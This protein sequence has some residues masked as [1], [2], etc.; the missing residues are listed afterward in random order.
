MYSLIR[1]LVCLC[2]V[3][4]LLFA[5]L[6]GIRQFVSEHQPPGTNTTIE[7]RTVILERLRTLKELH[8][9]VATLQ[10]IVTDTQSSSLFGVGMGTNKV[11]YI[12]VGEV[13][14]GVNL[15]KLGEQDITVHGKSVRIALSDPEI[16]DAKIDVNQSG[17]YDV[18][19]STLFCPERYSMQDE[20]QR[21]ALVAIVEAAKSTALLETAREQAK[22]SITSLLKLMG[23]EVISIEFDSSN[24]TDGKSSEKQTNEA[25]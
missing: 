10:A 15:S 22:Q 14:A 19:C 17:L 12:A 23:F 4:V 7:V 2:F 11:I 3:C 8:T 18:R 20:V 24:S 1:F 16:L 13:R 6:K 21:K 9:A 25:K 5:I